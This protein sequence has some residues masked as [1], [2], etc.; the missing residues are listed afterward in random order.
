MTDIREVTPEEG[1][2]MLDQA[3]LRWLGVT[4][5]EF[6]RR[7]RSGVYDHATGDLH[8]RVERVRALLP[9]AGEEP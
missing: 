6:T 1:R 9:F 3:A 8:I 2:A 7:H 5:R 4:G